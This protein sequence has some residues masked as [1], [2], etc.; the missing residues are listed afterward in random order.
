M[1]SNK[2]YYSLWQQTPWHIREEDILSYSPVVMFR[3]TPC[4]YTVSHDSWQIVLNVFFHNM[5]SC[6]LPKI[7]IINVL[8]HPYYSKIDFLVKYIWVKCVF[9]TKL[10]AKKSLIS[11]TEC[12]RWHSKLFT[13]CHVLWDTLYLKL[14]IGKIFPKIRK[15]EDEL[16]L[17]R[18]IIMNNNEGAL[19]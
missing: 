6:L 15:I 7:I 5:S 14:E 13:N 3:G 11:N 1:P 18:K 8:W 17:E 16:M 10:T 4:I 19:S 12:G 9:K 2:Y